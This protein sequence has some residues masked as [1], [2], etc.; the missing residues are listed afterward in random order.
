M[1]FHP[2]IPYERTSSSL[3]HHPDVSEVTGKRIDWYNDST[4]SGY[5]GSVVFGEN[6]I[7]VKGLPMGKTPQY[8]EER[9][10]RYFSKYGPVTGCSAVGHPLDPY[11]CEG[12]A[13]VS[14]REFS[15]V[16][17]AMK[18]S[19]L[20][21]GL[22]SMGYR[23]ASLRALSTDETV[24]CKAS[25]RDLKTEVD[26][27]I[28]NLRDLHGR[29]GGVS[30]EEVRVPK[31]GFS[32]YSIQGD[33]FQLIASIFIV[34]ENRLSLFPRQL[35]NLEGELSL[36]RSALQK[37]V[38]DQCVS[39]HWREHAA[40]KK[41]PE[42]TQRRIR[43]WDRKDKLPSELQILSRDYRQHK[44]HDEK[45]LVKERKRRERIRSKREKAASV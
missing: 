5:E 1:K 29:I 4:K 28:S 22:R 20:R 12:T 39:I 43:M 26:Q 18:E 25:Y 36:I 17:R 21:F 14:F 35:I 9:M 16:S 24:D 23:S 31:F 2:T 8:M 3:H 34:S 44:I 7:E 41:L 32:N 27:V 45:F 13:Y 10:R 42:Y 37:S 19:V 11:Q 40:I 33:F 15:S 38:R 30:M 6:T